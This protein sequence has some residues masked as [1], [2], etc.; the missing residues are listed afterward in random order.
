MTTPKGGRGSSSQLDFAQAV[1][2]EAEA[3]LASTI[4]RRSHRSRSD[5]DLRAQGQTQS[6]TQSLLGRDREGRRPKH[7][8]MTLEQMQQ[9]VQD[10]AMARYLKNLDKDA[11]HA[12][13]EKLHWNDT[14]QGGL[15][16]DISE[17]RSQR[18]AAVHNQR[19]LR[20]QMEANKMRRA[21]NRRDYIEAA[22]SHS[23]PLFTETFICLEEV[24]A[25]ERDRKKRFRQELQDQQAAQQVMKNMQ[26]RKDRI[27]A[28]QKHH[29]NVHGMLNARTKERDNL[30][31]QGDE[32]VKAWD[33]DI[34]LNSIRKA[35]ETGKDIVDSTRS[36]SS[37]GRR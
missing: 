8:A 7:K 23:F 21:D 35:I 17:K 9:S 36:P 20:E 15:D 18:E 5:S 24:E 27:Y 26:K 19:Q 4:S 3:S 2:Q 16:K 31:R 34:R 10:D 6:P 29:E 32:L 22:S 37:M 1:R 25:Y 14:V 13:Y 33:R 28:E 11:K 12:Q 30:A